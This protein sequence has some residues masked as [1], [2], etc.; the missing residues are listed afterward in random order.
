MEE[1]ASLVEAAE[2]RESVCR[3]GAHE[4]E[5]LPVAPKDV[6][7]EESDAPGADAQGSWGK[8]I[9]VCAVEEGG[10]ECLCGDHVRRF[11][12][13]LSHQTDRTDRGFLGTFA[14]ATALKRS[15][16]VLTQG[17]HERSSFLR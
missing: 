3:L 7:G 15:N 16:H 6:V 11:A 12:I 4:V 17:S 5:G 9:D 10:L 13:A 2:S 14:L 1:P 8:A